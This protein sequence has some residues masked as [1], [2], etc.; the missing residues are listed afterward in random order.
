MTIGEL[1]LDVESLFFRGVA[2]AGG[3]AAVKVYAALG[4]NVN[5]RSRHNAG[6]DLDEVLMPGSGTDFSHLRQFQPGDSVKLIDWARSTKTGVPV[7]KDFEDSRQL[8]LFL[9]IDLDPTMDR[10]EGRTELET[11]VDLAILLSNYVLGNNERVGL[12]CFSGSDTVSCLFP[13][14]GKGMTA[15]LRQAI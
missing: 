12:A 6:L 10:G 8:P 13:G 1:E 4:R 9:L 15:R 3:D 14:S 5:S 2:K 7:V 11:A